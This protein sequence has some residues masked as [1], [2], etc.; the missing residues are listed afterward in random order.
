MI[1]KIKTTPKLQEAL[2]RLEMLGSGIFPETARAM[3]ISAAFVQRTWV[4]MA[5]GQ[6]LSGKPQDV[7]FRGSTD[8]ANSIRVISISPFHKTI[9]SDSKVG[10]R[11]QEGSPEVDMKPFLVHGPKSRVSAD[12]HRYNIIPFR[13]KV[14]KLQA[15]KIG[16]TTAYMLAKGLAKQ[17]IIGFKIDSE[18][19]R[20]FAYQKWTAEKKLDVKH[21]FLAGMVRMQTSAGAGHSSLYMTFRTVNLS[22]IGSWIKRGQSPWNIMKDVKDKTSRKVEEFIK[23]ALLR[24]VR[25]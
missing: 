12:G 2:S 21:R 14:K 10:K 16:N 8:Y 22:Q 7:S 19:K 23:Q 11:L 18:G 1:L 24:D 13:H 17:K 6:D 25:G 5:Q 15:I 4:N 3:N 9:V 20:R